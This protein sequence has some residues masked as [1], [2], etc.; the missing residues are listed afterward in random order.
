MLNPK[1]DFFNLRR[2]Y[3]FD[4]EGY[5]C[6]ECGA[7]IFCVEES[8]G[9]IKDVCMNHIHAEAFGI[10]GNKGC[11]F[12]RVIRDIQAFSVRDKLECTIRGL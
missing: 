3:S 5:L 6:P 4:A 10:A 8:D 2:G 12:M 7:R 9:T 11:L 1:E